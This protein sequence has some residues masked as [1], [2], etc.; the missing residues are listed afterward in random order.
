VTLGDRVTEGE[1]VAVGERESVTVRDSVT[2]FDNDTE[3]VAGLLLDGDVSIVFDSDDPD[4]SVLV[5][6]IVEDA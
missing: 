1:R 4:E 2:T 6:E 3:A 5:E